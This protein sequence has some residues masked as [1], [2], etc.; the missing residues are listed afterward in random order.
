MHQL[1]QSIAVIC[2]D[3]TK[4]Y[5]RS[6][7]NTMIIDSN[8][9]QNDTESNNNHQIYSFLANHF[10]K[11]AETKQREQKI[12]VSLKSV[13]DV[14]KWFFET[15]NKSSSSSSSS[16]PFSFDSL[17]S[18]SSS[19]N[20]KPD[21]Q[22]AS[23]LVSLQA[24]QALLSPSSIP[25]ANQRDI[26]SMLSNSIINGNNNNN[27][28]ALPEVFELARALQQVMQKRLNKNLEYIVN[29]KNNNKN[30]AQTSSNETTSS[31]GT[32]NTLL[33]VAVFSSLLSVKSLFQLFSILFENCKGNLRILQMIC[34]TYATIDKENTK[35]WN[36]VALMLSSSSSSS[37]KTID[38]LVDWIP[39]IE[40]MGQG[41]ASTFVDDVEEEVF[42]GGQ[43]NENTNTV[44]GGPVVVS[45]DPEDEEGDGRQ[46]GGNENTTNEGESEGDEDDVT[47]EVRNNFWTGLTS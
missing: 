17:S 35:V 42:G 28:S 7:E 41:R 16:T 2:A 19:K 3:A 15:T 1:Q 46:Q 13:Q 21:F 43:K 18:S 33:F 32:T 40:T 39:S 38:D 24:Y 8:K 27:T 25:R 12:A 4:A 37:I 5:I 26:T 29:L 34:V 6:D 23:K 22:S 47:D 10:Q 20:E 9:N 45:Y 31:F 11:L 36:A 30:L 14:F 44:A